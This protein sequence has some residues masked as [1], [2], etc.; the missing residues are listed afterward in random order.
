MSCSSSGGIG[1]SWRAQ[2]CVE[3]RAS[4]RPASRAA[5][6]ARGRPPRTPARPGSSAS[7]RAAAHAGAPRAASSPRRRPP[8]ARRACA[9]RAPP[10]GAAAV[11]PA[12]CLLEQL[13]PLLRRRREQTRPPA[14]RSAAS[15]ARVGSPPAPPRPGCSAATAPTPPPPS[16][17]P[18]PAARS[19]SARRTSSSASASRRHTQLL[20]RPSSTRDLRLA[21]LVLPVQRAHQPRLLELAQARR[22][23]CSTTAAPSRRPHRARAPRPAASATTAA[24]AARNRLRPSNSSSLSPTRYACTGVS[25]P[26]R[27]ERQLHLL[28]RLRGAQPHRRKRFAQLTRCQLQCP[29]LLAGHDQHHAAPERKNPDRS[30]TVS[31][32][33][34]VFSNNN[35]LLRIE[36]GQ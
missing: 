8:A 19:P 35:Q 15:S 5:R 34:G 25:C 28:L 6:R 17:P 23:R 30:V 21:E 36:A 12:R 32:S 3:G 9:A 10:L 1:C 18:V 24:R 29:C 7:A 26:S 4:G 33:Q 14:A 20:C 13:G 31:H 16:P 11:P 2:A 22:W 27:R